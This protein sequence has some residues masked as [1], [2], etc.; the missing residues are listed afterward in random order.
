MEFTL[1]EEKVEAGIN[2]CKGAVKNCAKNALYHLRM[3]WNLR[4]TDLEM[5]V[6]RGIT[7]EEEAASSVFY[8]LKNQRYKN[9]NRIKFKEHT[10]KQALYPYIRSILHYLGGL[11]EHNGS[12]IENYNIQHVDHSHRKAL[13]LNLKLRNAEYY[14]SPIPPLHFNI[15]NPDTGKVYTFEYSFK[16]IAQG[17]AYDSALKYVKEIADTRNRIL[18]AT[19]R[20]QPRVEG[21]IASYIKEQKAKVFSMLIIVLLVDPW[22]DEGYSAFVQQALDGFL[23]LLERIEEHEVNP[24]HKPDNE[25]IT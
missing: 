19:A 21:D 7:A 15:S 12:P 20:G 14:A 13:Q 24:P 2:D 9:S 22:L 4:D 16:Q 11:N 8:T 1:F 23:F 10:Y 3:A 17:E 6:F 18:Y 5:A 25:Q